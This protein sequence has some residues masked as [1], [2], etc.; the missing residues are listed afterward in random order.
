MSTVANPSLG[1]VIPKTS[2]VETDLA[3]RLRLA[4]DES[5]W[6]KVLLIGGT[7]PF[8]T[9]VLFVP[10]AAI[11]AEA[12][13]KGVGVYVASFTDPHALSAIRLTLLVAAICVPLN[14]VFGLAAAWAIAKFRFPGKSI[15]ITL[16]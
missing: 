1:G 13:R 11:F 15:L 10:L 16:I 14:V 9:L 8:L 3:G 12:F 7:L 2:L 4:T 5:V 6:V